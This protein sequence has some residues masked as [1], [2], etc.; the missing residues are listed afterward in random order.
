[1]FRREFE[2]K[3]FK[4]ISQNH[5]YYDDIQKMYICNHF[6]MCPNVYGKTS[7]HMLNQKEFVFLSFRYI[8][9]RIYI[10]VKRRE[11][12]HFQ[13]VYKLGQTCHAYKKF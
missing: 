12:I 10:F 1:M 2:P 11:Q 6:T 13:V 8:L 7:M 9:K 4:I 3:T 5:E